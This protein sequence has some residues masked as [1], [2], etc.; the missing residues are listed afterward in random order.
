MIAATW[1]GSAS[2]CGTLPDGMVAV[3]P[4]A[5]STATT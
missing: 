4:E 5:R 3:D 1:S 2:G